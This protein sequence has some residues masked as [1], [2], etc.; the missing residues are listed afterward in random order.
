MLAWQCETA[1]GSY[2]IGT[3]IK[4]LISVRNSVYETQNWKGTLLVFARVLVIYIFNVYAAD[5]MPVLSNLLMNLH[6]L[7][8]AVISIFIWALACHQSAEAVFVT[9]WKDL[10]G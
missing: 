6:I 10:G 7:S 4:R 2:L 1:S 8:W 9:Q 5:S 3:I